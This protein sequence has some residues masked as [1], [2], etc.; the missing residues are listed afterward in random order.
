MTC[1][2]CVRPQQVCHPDAGSCG[3]L[4]SIAVEA[5]LKKS[6]APFRER[7]F[8]FSACNAMN[9]L[10]EDLPDYFVPVEKTKVFGVALAE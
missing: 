4:G 10:A 3:G 6:A 5:D 1:A 2:A 7:P 8:C 9:R